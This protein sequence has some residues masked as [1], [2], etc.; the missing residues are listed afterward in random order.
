MRHTLASRLRPFALAGFAAALLTAAALAQT[1][2]EQQGR[3]ATVIQACVNKRT[4]FLRLISDTGRCRHREQAISWNEQGPPGKPGPQG[5][6]GPQGEEGP[7]GPQGEPGPAGPPGPPGP[8]GPP[9]AQGPPGPQG[10]PG[11][12]GPPGPGVASL[13]DLNGLACT[14]GGRAGTIALAYDTENRAVLTCVIPG[15]SGSRGGG[16]DGG[17]PRI[18]INEFMT[19]SSGAAANEFVE[20]VNAGTAPAN[21]SGF[22]L[23]YRSAAGTSDTTLATIPDGT[24]LAPG[25][26]YLFAGSG[27]AGSPAADQSFSAGLAAAGGG[28]GLRD[29]GGALVDSVGYGTATNAFVE[30]SPATAPPTVDTPGA[31]AVRI[32]DGKDT[33]DNSA[34]FSVGQPPSP[35]ASNG[36]G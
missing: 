28:I 8:Q 10:P 21:L 31:S 3:R 17:E 16:G 14:V 15:G 27:Y 30:T 11:R 9:G 20:I 29:A 4:G 7:P 26:F 35:R 32:P 6:P 13:D 25:S 23:V 19:G 34:D 2:G 1:E 18:R 24:V 5:P 22:K 33:N 36:S 12:Q